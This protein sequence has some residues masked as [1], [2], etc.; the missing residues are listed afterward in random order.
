MAMTAQYFSKCTN[1][2]IKETTCFAPIIQSTAYGFVCFINVQA[3][4]MSVL[5]IIKTLNSGNF[6]F[7]FEKGRQ[8]SKFQ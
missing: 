8:Q 1:L 7:V 3:D 2:N 4:F 5:N 6:H